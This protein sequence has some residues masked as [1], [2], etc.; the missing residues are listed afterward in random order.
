[1]AAPGEFANDAAYE[2]LGITE[3]HERIVEIVKRIIDTR[4]AGLMPR[5]MTITVWALSTSR[6]G[7]P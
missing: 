7:I 3:Q 2:S 6:I 4:E 1:V 5:L